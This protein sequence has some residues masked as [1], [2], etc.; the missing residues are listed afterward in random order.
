MEEVLTSTEAQLDVLAGPFL[1]L[2]A[3]G[4]ILFGVLT[5][6]VY[7]YWTTYV[8]ESPWMRSYVLSVWLLECIHTA[9][10]LHAMYTYF[11]RFLNH[12]DAGLA[13]IIWSTATAVLLSHIIVIITQGFYIYRIWQLSEG[14]WL[15][16]A[17]PS[18]LLIAKLALSLA[19]CQ[20]FFR[21]RTW[22]ELRMDTTAV[23]VFDSAIAVCVATDLV[24]TSIFSYYLKQ[25]RLD[26]GRT[27]HVIDKLL[28][29]T[30]HTSAITFVVS[31]SI[32]IT[33][34]ALEHSLAFVGIIGAISKVYG[35][36]MLAMLNARREIRDKLEEAFVNTLHL[37]GIHLEQLA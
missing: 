32:L 10:W 31:G 23:A 12:A 30:V 34:H 8:T 35:T 22:E 19:S 17:V 29:Y 2:L 33:F 36:T 7:F 21:F 27:R 4:L 5:C 16:T 9:L 6:Q 26:Y 28:R 18:F 11:V 3:V 25:N 15:F 13:M 20:F 37:S 1:L 14:C 24:T